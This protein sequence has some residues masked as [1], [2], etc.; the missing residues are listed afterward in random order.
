M[1]EVAALAAA[2]L[3]A[4]TVVT[5]LYLVR[6]MRVLSGS[7]AEASIDLL[8]GLGNRRQLMEDL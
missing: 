3:V 1:T 7:R 4:A 5:I 2:A 8:T 6:H